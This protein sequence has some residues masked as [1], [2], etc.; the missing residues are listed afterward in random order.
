VTTVKIK[1]RFQN[2]TQR[3]ALQQELKLYLPLIKYHVIMT[4]REVELIS[5]EILILQRNSTNFVGKI[6][7]YVPQFKYLENAISIMDF[8]KYTERSKC[9]N[10]SKF[11]A[12]VS[13]TRHSKLVLHFKSQCLVLIFGGYL[14]E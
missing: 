3:A 12:T 1:S 5:L 8:M 10:S 9:S 7:E 4:Y 13:N 6:S 2:T 14:E 11:R